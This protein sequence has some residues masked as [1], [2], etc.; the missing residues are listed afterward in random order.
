[1]CWVTSWEQHTAF[2]T[3]LPPYV[4]AITYAARPGISLL[5]SSWLGQCLTLAPVINMKAEVGSKEDKEWLANALFYLRKPS[6]G[7]LEGD[8]RTLSA[9]IQR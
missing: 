9:E 3:V 5:S 7:S 2:R 8:I 1:M 6:T 4:F